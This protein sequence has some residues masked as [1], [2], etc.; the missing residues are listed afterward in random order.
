MTSEL[1]LDCNFDLKAWLYVVWTSGT[2]TRRARKSQEPTG[3]CSSQH[4]HAHCRSLNVRQA[5]VYAQ[6]QRRQ[7]QPRLALYILPLY[8]PTP[9][10]HSNLCAAICAVLARVNIFLLLLTY[11]TYSSSSQPSFSE[12][13]SMYCAFDHPISSSRLHSASFPQFYQNFAPALCGQ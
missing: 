3:S 8:T 2:R 1:K 9:S 12:N 10:S 4:A 11:S 6:G 7:P 13:G 5:H